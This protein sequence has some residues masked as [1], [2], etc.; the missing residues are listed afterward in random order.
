MTAES[1]LF[2]GILASAKCLPKLT[3]HPLSFI[4]GD[5]YL[6][7]VRKPYLKNFDLLSVADILLAGLKRYD[8]SQHDNRA[9][10][11]NGLHM[12]IFPP[13]SIIR[14]R[15]VIRLGQLREFKGTDLRL[16]TVQIS[17]SDMGRPGARFWLSVKDQATGESL[18]LELI[19][20]PNE[21]PFASNP[22]A[23][24]YR[25]RVNGNVSTKVKEATLTEIFNRLRGWVVGRVKRSKLA[26]R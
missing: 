22:S 19:P 17:C 21:S 13:I 16:A 8:V 23:G 15:H 5:T 20:A 25:I 18:K 6:L 2:L 12:Q 24:R 11:L 26:A 14:P 3:V 10:D 7:T 4:T 1:A 9:V